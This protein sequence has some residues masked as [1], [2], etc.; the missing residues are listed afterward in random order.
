MDVAVYGEDGKALI[1][2][3][4]KASERV[5][6]KLC[7]KLLSS[8]RDAVP[9]PDEEE[10]KPEDAIMKAQHIWLHRP[11]Y[12]WAVCPTLKVSYAVDFGRDGFTLN[13][14]GTIPSP[15]E[16]APSVPAAMRFA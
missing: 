5:L 10:K 3:E 13:R 9:F 6:D 16:W 7:A 2:A 1:Y 8:Y 4:N 15:L 14:V 12:F 11:R